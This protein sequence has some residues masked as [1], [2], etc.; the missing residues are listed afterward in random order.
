MRLARARLAPS[1]DRIVFLDGAEFC[2]DA[3][4]S[5]TG[6]QCDV[7]NI[8]NRTDTVLRIGAEQACHPLRA[9]GTL[10]ACVIGYDGLGKNDRWLDLQLDN[11]KLIQWLAEGNAPDGVRYSIDALARE[12]S[13]AFAGLDHWSC[14]T[15]D[16]NRPL[17]RDLVLSDVMTVARMT[18]HGV[19]AGTDAP[20][21]GCFNGQS[22]PLTPATV[23]ERR[24][25]MAQDIASA[26][27]EGSG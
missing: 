22:I 4:A 25:L 27:G 11:P 13:H 14:Y 1:L 7:F 16:G 18:L 15:N 21:Y 23:T 26:G 3:A 2:V 12:H 5:F 6:C 19:P 17:V 24:R 10:G 9:N 8:A 20:A